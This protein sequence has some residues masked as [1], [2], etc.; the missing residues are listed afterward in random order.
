MKQI[1]DILGDIPQLVNMVEGGGK[2]PILPVEE[3]EK[4]GFSIAIFPCTPW[5]AAIKAMQTILREL[6]EEGTTE[7]VKDQMVSFQEMFEIVGYSYYRDLEKR[8][9]VD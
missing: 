3:L 1:V 9:S 6:K 7:A 5:M 8:F 4:I 2:T